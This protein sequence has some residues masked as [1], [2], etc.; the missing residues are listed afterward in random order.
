MYSTD[1]EVMTRNNVGAAY[2]QLGEWTEV[3]HWLESAFARTA[4]ELLAQVEG[5]SKPT[6]LNGR[7]APP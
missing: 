2:L 1:P 4:Q 6:S 7:M 3:R 5:R